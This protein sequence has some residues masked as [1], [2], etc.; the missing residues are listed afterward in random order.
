MLPSPDLDFLG[1]STSQAGGEQP[2][3]EDAYILVADDDPDARVIMCALLKMLD[4]DAVAVS[5]GAEAL[6]MI[7][8]RPPSLIM[9]DLMMPV[10]NGFELLG[11]LKAV[12]A[13]RD[14]PVIILSALGKDKRLA[15]LGADMVIQKGSLTIDRLHQTVQDSLAL[16]RGRNV[17]EQLALAAGSKE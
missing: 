6:A 17:V 8:A 10:M 4:W 2:R 5:N 11:H 16:V 7:T 14:I 13:T 9:I 3:E 12:P 15:R 1:R